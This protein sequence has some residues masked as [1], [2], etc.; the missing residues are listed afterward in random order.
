MT[1]FRGAPGVTTQRGRL[2]YRHLTKLV[3]RGAG[4]DFTQRRR[5]IL[6]DVET[7]LC[8]SGEKCR[9]DGVPI[10]LVD[11]VSLDRPQVTRETSQAYDG[12]R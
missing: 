6:A 1:L 9:T 11:G 12:N 2:I 5:L 10:S 7:H 3:S 8:R 4:C